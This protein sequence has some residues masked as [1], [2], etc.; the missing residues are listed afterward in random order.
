MKPTKREVATNQPRVNSMQ[1]GKKWFSNAFDLSVGAFLAIWEH[2]KSRGKKKALAL[3]KHI[4]HMMD[5]TSD[6][7]MIDI[8]PS[9][10]ERISKRDC[11]K[12]SEN[13]LTEEEDELFEDASAWYQTI[14]Q[15]SP[16]QDMTGS[17]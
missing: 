13:K 12:N 8:P 14:N 17:M 11:F 5:I 9:D 10:L 7:P 4:F 16:S 2:D 1:V 15:R 3:L 6:N